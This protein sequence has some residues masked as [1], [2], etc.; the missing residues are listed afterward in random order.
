M[1]WGDWIIVCFW[2]ACIVILILSL[3]GG[4][5]M[6]AFKNPPPPPLRPDWRDQER[7]CACDEWDMDKQITVI[8][9]RKCGRKAWVKEYRDLFK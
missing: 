3:R 2:I 1:E 8:Q 9:C 4:S 7:D 6:P 5:R